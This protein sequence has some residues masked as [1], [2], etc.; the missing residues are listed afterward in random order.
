MPILSENQVGIGDENG[1]TKDV[2][3]LVA[4][5]YCDKLM[6]PR[7][8]IGTRTVMHPTKK[9]IVFYRTHRSCADEALPIER[10]QL[11]AQALVF[12][13]EEN[14]QTRARGMLQ[15]H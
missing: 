12:L 5:P 7:G 11:D 13:E 8:N 4:C 14:D 3:P 1:V 10:D 2:S 15:K 6:N 9:Q